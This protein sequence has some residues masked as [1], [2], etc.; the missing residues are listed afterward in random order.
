MTLRHIMLSCLCV[1]LLP[2]DVLAEETQAK[3]TESEI[4]DLFSQG[5][6]LFREANETAA[7]DN[8]AAIEL[9][10]KA[11]LRFERIAREG[12]VDNG[13]LYYNI[14]NA[15]FRMKDIGRAILNYRRAMEYLPGNGQLRE[16]LAHA[17]DQRVD[18]FE[19]TERP[20]WLEWLF[21]W[22][23]KLDDGARLALFVIAYA[24]IWVLALWRLFVGSRGQETFRQGQVVC[25]IVCLVTGISM[26]ML[27]WRAEE[28][29]AA[30]VITDEVE[31]RKGDGFI[32]E[33]AFKSALHTGTEV[34]ITEIRGDWA[35]GRFGNG[36]AAW[37]PREA[38]A[39]VAP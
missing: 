12:G 15:Y 28:S 16:S 22:H 27:G 39:L 10:Q 9:Y 36:D 38:I 6:E 11:A 18:V 17:R 35:K 13:K 37:L 20:A 1:F 34:E 14:G 19:V 24:A 3:L 30:V 7:R 2:A 5:K 23:F 25:L 32:Y 29:E 8:A 26:L 33:P 31:A 21:F 4:A